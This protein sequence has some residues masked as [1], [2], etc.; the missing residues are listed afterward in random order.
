MNDIFI[1]PARSE[2]L[3][4]ILD[5]LKQQKV[6]AQGLSDH[7]YDARRAERWP[8]HRQRRG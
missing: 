8:D 3:P 5:L 4:A 2:D 6:P 1:E 7:L